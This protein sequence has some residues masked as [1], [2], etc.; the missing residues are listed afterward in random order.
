MGVEKGEVYWNLFGLGMTPLTKLSRHP[1]FL[2]EISLA[3][4]I[5]FSLISCV[6]T[7]CTIS[8]MCLPGTDFP[9]RRFSVSS[10]IPLRI[11]LY[12]SIFLCQLLF[13]LPIVFLNDLQGYWKNISS[14]VVT[15]FSTSHSNTKMNLFPAS[16]NKHTFISDPVFQLHYFILSFFLTSHD[17]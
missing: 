2:C 5:C 1:F 12:N 17:L 9:I 4:S 6:N 3:N 16:P 14:F 8:D 7:C 13:F 15:I 10:L 11:L